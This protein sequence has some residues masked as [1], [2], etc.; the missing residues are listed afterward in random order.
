M[1]LEF[2]LSPLSRVRAGPSSI[3]LLR[4]AT[5]PQSPHHTP[6]VA[7][8]GPRADRLMKA[9]ADGRGMGAVPGAVSTDNEW[10]LVH[11]V[12]HEAGHAVVAER[13]GFN[14]RI[15]IGRADRFGTGACYVAGLRAASEQIQRQIGLAGRMADLQAQHG[16]ALTISQTID[17]V[18]WGRPF[19]DGDRELI[20]S[21]ASPREI[22]VC[23]RRV[24][25]QWDDVI[26]LARMHLELELGY[27]C[28]GIQ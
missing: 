7:V 27:Y 25:L 17:A 4:Q 11:V 12:V 16:S 21:G 15:E 6:G 8:D 22:D 24:Q 19:S 5:G 10:I 28:L 23:Q 26:E 13:W 9:A 14:S 3:P 18:R 20:G 1:R 2:N